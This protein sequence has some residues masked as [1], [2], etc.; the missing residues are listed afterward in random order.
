MANKQQLEHERQLKAQNN[1]HKE[2][3]TTGEEAHTHSRQPGAKI[4]RIAKIPRYTV[5]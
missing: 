2:T 1:Q 5:L 3:C 4:E